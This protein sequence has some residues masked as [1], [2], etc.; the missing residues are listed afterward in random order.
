MRAKPISFE[1]MG[2]DF[3]ITKTCDSHFSPQ[4]SPIMKQRD[5]EKVHRHSNMFTS[6]RHCSLVWDK[7]LAV[8]IFKLKNPFS[9][10]VIRI[11]CACCMFLCF[12]SRTLYEYNTFGVIGVGIG[13]WKLLFFHVSCIGHISIRDFPHA[14]LNY[15]TQRFHMKKWAVINGASNILCVVPESH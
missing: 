8:L 14:K 5:F 2:P 7:N 6:P 11:R 13:P 12:T 9:Q 10:H 1:S 3:S 4:T 15:R